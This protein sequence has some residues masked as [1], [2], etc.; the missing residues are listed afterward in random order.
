[1]DFV[2]VTHLDLGKELPKAAAGIHLEAF[3]QLQNELHDNGL[4]SH[5]LHQWVFLQRKGI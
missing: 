5:L 1:M 3:C 4:M 2:A